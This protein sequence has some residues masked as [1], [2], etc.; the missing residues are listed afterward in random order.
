MKR[1]LDVAA[2][3][4]LL[5]ILLPVI[6]IIVVAVWVDVGWPVLFRQCRGGLEGRV[7][8]I[9]KFRTMRTAFGANGQ[10]LS[11]SE[12]MTR[13]GRFLRATSL[14]EIPQL[15]NIIVGD[16]SFVG[17]RP[18]IAE[19]LPLYTKEQARRHQVR[20]GLTGITQVR[21]RNMLSWE[22]RFAYD[23][24]YVDNMAAML[25]LKILL[26]T[27]VSVFTARGVTPIGEETMSNFLG[28]VGNAGSEIGA[29][30]CN[31][32]RRDVEDR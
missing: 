5:V 17:P 14:D 11:D 30:T 1:V 21:G 16:M 28:S 3:V 6:F 22:D 15:W 9:V 32:I 25:D 31:S 2:A 8:R 7:F 12:R 20:P 27:I 29:T 4:I 19:Y 23:V 10:P 26:W 24:W 18:L 13:L